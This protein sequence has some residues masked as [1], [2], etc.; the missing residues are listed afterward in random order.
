MRAHE[1]MMAELDRPVSERR[2]DGR[3]SHWAMS[4]P[5]ARGGDGNVMQGHVDYCAE[6]GHATDT[7]DGVV[8]SWCPRCGDALTPNMSAAS[9][10]LGRL[11]G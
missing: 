6:H 11:L 10:Y 1:D 9:T 4:F 3:Y 2:K 7:R 8:M 5:L